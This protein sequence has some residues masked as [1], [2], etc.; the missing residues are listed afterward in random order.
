MD[1]LVQTMLSPGLRNN[2]NQSWQDVKTLTLG[3]YRLHW[4]ANGSQFKRCGVRKFLTPRL[5]SRVRLACQ[6]P[7]LAAL[8]RPIPLNKDCRMAL[9]YM[10]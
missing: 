10:S 3:T 1:V 6:F 7:L 4:R 9:H 8:L 2:C 5:G